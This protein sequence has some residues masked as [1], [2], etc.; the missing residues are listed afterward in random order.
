VI[1][2]EDEDD[3]DDKDPS[4]SKK[5]N[6][7]CVVPKDSPPHLSLV[8]IPNNDSTY[9][10]FKFV[11]YGKKELNKGKDKS[12]TRR[13]YRCVQ[14]DCKA[15]YNLTTDPSGASHT[16]HNATSYNHQPSKNP[17]MCKEIKAKVL[18]YFGIGATPAIVHKKLVNEAPQPL[19]LADTPS[20]SQLKNWKYR[21]SMKDIPSGKAFVYCV[22]LLSSFS[23]IPP[24]YC[25]FFN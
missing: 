3:D 24:N 13:Y 22:F 9:E 23:P 16:K 11:T 2:G 25:F 8:N 18:E 21:N 7:S 10:M 1:E 12:S 19:S 4:P 5:K 6:A 20:V 14:Q 17:H 15:H